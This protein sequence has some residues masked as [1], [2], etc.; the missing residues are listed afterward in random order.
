MV[1]KEV[2]LIKD[3]PLN[4]HQYFLEVPKGVR[5]LLDKSR[6]LQELPARGH[7]LWMSYS[8]SNCDDFKGW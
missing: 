3:S 4:H 7:Q 1:G 5:G 6:E 8:H 2:G